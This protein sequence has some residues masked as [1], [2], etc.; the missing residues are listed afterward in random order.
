[1][2]TRDALRDAGVRI[3]ALFGPE[4]GFSATIA[5]AE[6]VPSSRDRRTG[7]PIYSLFGDIYKPTP[8][9]LDGIDALVYD[10]Q[11]VGVRFYTF[12]TTLAFLLEACA[13]H[14]LPSSCDR[15]N[16]ITGLLVEGPLLVSSQQSFL[17][18]GPSHC[19]MD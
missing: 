10:L 12:T 6:P 15:P 8:A 16:P 7:L 13:E 11:D 9:M 17:G 5:D 4:H 2:P 19:A 1:V 14:H 18:H 3:V